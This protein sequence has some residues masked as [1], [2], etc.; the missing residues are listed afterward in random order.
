MTAILGL[1]EGQDLGPPVRPRHPGSHVTPREKAPPE[2][3]DRQRLSL[4]GS[5]CSHQ[6]AC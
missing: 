4:W 5:G 2:P 1:E 6:V 3:L